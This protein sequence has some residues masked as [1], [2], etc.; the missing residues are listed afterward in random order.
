M[1]YTVGWFVILRF[2]LYIYSQIQTCISLALD[3]YLFWGVFYVMASIS[4]QIRAMFTNG[5]GIV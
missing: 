3:I 2:C 1:F 4:P 5:K